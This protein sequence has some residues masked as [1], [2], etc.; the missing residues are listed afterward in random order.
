V[1]Y[2]EDLEVGEKDVLEAT[3]YQRKRL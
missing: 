3:R 1:R 2:F